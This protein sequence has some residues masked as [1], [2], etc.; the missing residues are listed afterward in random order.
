MTRIRHYKGYTIEY[1][2]NGVTVSTIT[3]SGYH[4]HQ[5]YQ[6]YT[7]RECIALFKEYVNQ[8][9]SQFIYNEA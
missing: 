3:D 4:I 1:H 5:L 8:F 6:G 9:E 7:F 2:H